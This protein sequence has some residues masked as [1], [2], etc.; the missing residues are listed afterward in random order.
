MIYVGRCLPWLDGTGTENCLIDPSLPVRV[1]TMRSQSDDCPSYA[2]LHP[3]HR[4]AYLR[5]LA[6]GRAAPDIDIGL[7]TLYFY[8]LERRLIG[9]RSQE[10]APAIIAEVERLRQI[11]G[12]DDSFMRNTDLFLNTARLI[13][14]GVPNEPPELHDRYWE[15]PLGL[16]AGLGQRI[17]AGETIDGAWMLAWLHCDPNLGWR[18]PATRAPEQFRALFLH[19][20]TKCFPFGITVKPPQHKLRPTY[21][22]CSG[23]FQVSVSI[24]AELPDVTA[25][26]APLDK[27]RPLAEASMDKLDAYSR[28]LGRN[29]DRRD[30]LEAFALLPVELRTT[31][32]PVVVALRGWLD[33][34]A[35]E[36]PALVPWAEVLRRVN[37]TA[38]DKA[39]KRDMQGLATSLAVLGYGIEPDPAFGGRLP[40]PDE[41]LALF[42]NSGP[43]VPIS[44]TPVANA[45]ASDAYRGALLRLTLA[46]MVAGADGDI[47]AEERALF[48]AHIADAPDLSEAE[49]RR[50]AAHAHWLEACP[51]DHNALKAHAA[52]LPVEE[53]DNV[54]QLAIAMAAADGRIDAKEI[55]LLQ[56]L[57]KLLGLDPDTLFSDLHAL[58]VDDRTGDDRANGSVATVPE[59]E[60]FGGLRLDP[61]RIRRI[62]A[63]TARVSNVLGVVFADE[64]PAPEPAL[65]EPALP[66]PALPAATTAE[67]TEETTAEI[68]RTEGDDRF[69][70]LDPQHRTLLRELCAAECWNRGDYTALARSLGLM[71]DG[72]LETINEWAFDRF[73]EA[74][75]DEGDPITVAL[76]LLQPSVPEPAA[77]V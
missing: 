18:T 66:E 3:V 11:Y 29:P 54:G 58:E 23:T 44:N 69:A 34:L 31:P 38:P 6:E 27:V 30:S 14:N 51:P 45:S 40:R 12:G 55:K 46:V 43:K 28:F 76:S 63:D 50:L 64:V 17:A 13:C 72:A 42:R 26:S 56:K 74:V 32:P 39:G 65:P 5:W 61:E 52:I 62:Q 73:D 7:V 60:P 25:L 70:G 33:G 57:Y 75:L 48:A 16:K 20:F 68:A 77:H 22:A 49:R 71:P 24:G 15:I 35:A 4:Y 47:A 41:P 59:P 8:G 19:H 36:R 10:D 53:R 2:R 37:G 9:D 67:A 21:E 1:G